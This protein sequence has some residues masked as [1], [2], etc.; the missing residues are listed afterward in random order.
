MHSLK[1]TFVA[2][3]LL[4]VSYFVYNGITNP[5]ADPANEE[6]GMGIELEI[7][8]G[9]LVDSPG[10]ESAPPST[11]FPQRG[12]SQQ[13]AFKAPP[14]HQ[15][16]SNFPS[17][18][19]RVAQ[20]NPNG[21]AAAKLGSSAPITD[22]NNQFRPSN[23][24]PQRNSAPES[25]AE[26]PLTPVAQRGSM[27]PG[28]MHQAN[29]TPSTFKN[30]NDF[31]L[32][33]HTSGSNSNS[34]MYTSTTASIET[35]W[36]E[37]DQ[38]VRE[39]NF[40]D[41]LRT[42][43]PFY[44]SNNLSDEQR[45][46]MLEW[47][48][49]LAGKVIYSSEHN[50]FPSAYVIQANDTMQSIAQQWGVPAQLVYNV[51]QAKISNPLTLTPGN[52][53]KVIKG[54]FNASLD[55]NRQTLTLFLNEMYAG[56]FQA[57]AITRPDPGTYRVTSK[58]ANGGGLGSFQVELTHTETGA[59]CNFH[60]AEFAQGS[61]GLSPNDAEDLFGILSTGSTVTIN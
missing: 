7:P 18:P 26:T 61:I 54:P 3:V 29:P 13:G 15:P 41:A 31:Q 10:T 1:N 52:E 44:R 27:Q 35:A 51:N 14:L 58:V 53:L 6:A 25:F 33:T 39:Q 47:L 30:R 9:S 43:S 49:A 38:L 45:R 37:V 60:A 50:L 19:A 23:Q 55:T 42:L 4:G 2:V 24:P 46:K 28:S 20:P 5:V 17:Q 8:D 32:A 56:R 11:G 16:D 12:P 40:R 36:P 57:T 22:N 59:K 48:D 21:L 34:D